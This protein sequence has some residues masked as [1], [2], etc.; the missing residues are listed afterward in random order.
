[1]ARSDEVHRF[2]EHTLTQWEKLVTEQIHTSTHECHVMDLARYLGSQVRA[3]KD[4]LGFVKIHD[5]N[6][7]PIPGDLSK[8]KVTFR[9]YAKPSG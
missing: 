6:I 9:W 3:L 4:L 7:D 8:V 1:M 5:L 2:V